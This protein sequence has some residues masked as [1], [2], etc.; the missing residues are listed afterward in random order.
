MLEWFKNKLG[1]KQQF[2][3]QGADSLSYRLTRTRY[4]FA[5]DVGDGTGSSSIMGPVQWIQRTFPEAPLMVTKASAVSVNQEVVDHPLTKLINEPNKFYGGSHLWM[6][7]IFSWCLSGNAYWYKVRNRIG[8]VIELWYIPHWYLTPK[9]PDDRR[10][11]YISHYEHKVGSQKINLPVSEVV[12]F[13]HGI[14]PRNER[15]GLAPLNSVIR[16]VWSD[17]EASNW[18][19]SLLRNSGIPGI[20]IS[21]DGQNNVGALIADASDVKEK[22]R[23]LFTGDRRGEPI[24]MRGPTK[25]TEY[26]Y[27]PSKMDLSTVRN[28]AEERACAVLGIPAAV[29]GFGTGLENS[30]VGA[31]MKEFVRM[32][33][34]DGI[35][36]MQRIMANEVRRSLL[37]DFTDAPE[38]FAVGFNYANVAALQEDQTALFTRA[39]QGVTRGWLTVAH[40]KRMVGQDVEDTDEVYLRGIGII[41]VPLGEERLEMLPEPDETD[42]DPK[43][44]ADDDDA[45]DQEKAAIRD[46]LAAGRSIQLL[47]LSST[48]GNGTKANQD[49]RRRL[50][51]RRMQRVMAV[52]DRL[53]ARLSKKFA[54][55]LEKLY[56]KYGAAAYTAA[57]QAL[58]KQAAAAVQ[59]KDDVDIIEAILRNMPW[60][61]LKLN[62]A[63]TYDAN[64]LNITRE[65]FNSMNITLGLAT[66]L[67]D[68]VARR[69]IAE[70]GRRLGLVDIQKQA[71]KTLF[72]SLAEGRALGEGGDT[73]ARR[74]RD[75]LPAGPW[76]DSKVRARVVARTETLHAQR[77]SVLEFTKQSG[78]QQVM[79]FDARLGDTDEDC[80][81]RD[82]QIVDLNT[83]ERWMEE[84]HPNGTMSFTPWFADQ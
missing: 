49:Q 54:A 57:R 80:E 35:M 26:G 22:L 17:D 55:D 5:R 42:K 8:D 28:T 63:K 66:D 34:T 19:A 64:Y 29:V 20:V 15:M 10:D 77:D 37:T 50:L 1:V 24:V 13:R 81:A 12:H 53:G 75:D 71:R 73:L 69:V 2:I 72:D 41:E 48:N 70:G 67:P 56:A 43:V 62:A 6:A 32:A 7:T 18:I 4:N 68:V 61:Q 27:D 39:N 3:P 31:T 60:A 46:A 30:K 47:N 44:P 82:Q 59:Y 21:P 51:V 23:D 33:W 84:E 83:A 78:A 65:T 9:W 74:I 52:Q 16:E 14:D 58:G 25:I 36:P 79:V 45:D 76:S 11:V 40:A 38:K